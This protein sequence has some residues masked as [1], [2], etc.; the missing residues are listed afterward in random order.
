MW[1][2]SCSTPA[3][4]QERIKRD[5]KRASLARRQIIADID[6]AVVDH[7]VERRFDFGVLELFLHA[8]DLGLRR[9]IGGQVAGDRR[10]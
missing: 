2:T 5:D 7:A 6:H 9:L 10:G 8:L 4:D 1:C 3:H